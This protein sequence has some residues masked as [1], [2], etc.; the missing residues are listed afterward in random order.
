MTEAIVDYQFSDKM[1]KRFDDLEKKF[2]EKKSLV[3]WA[4]HLVQEEAGYIPPSAITYVAEKTGVSPSHVQGVI[5]FYAM[6]HQ[7]PLGKYHIQI[8]VNAS[9]WLAGSDDLEETV[10]KKLE[11]L[12]GET[13]SDG[14]FTYNRQGECLAACGTA[15]IVQLNEEY[16]ENMT[17]EKLDNLIE[18]LRIKGK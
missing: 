13:T 1:Q 2:P 4:L 7:K 17:P 15:P 11:I 5:S 8:C 10:Q 12:P 6:F 3:L 14:L 9:C 16:H 18:G